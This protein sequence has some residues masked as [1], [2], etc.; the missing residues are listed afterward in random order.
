MNATENYKGIEIFKSRDAWAIKLDYLYYFEYD[1]K[2]MYNYTIDDC[3]D[4]IDNLLDE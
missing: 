1:N 2:V 3:K 4:E